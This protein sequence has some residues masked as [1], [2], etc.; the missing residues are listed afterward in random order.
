[1]VPLSTG[2]LLAPPC[3]RDIPGIKAR[4]NGIDCRYERSGD[5]EEKMERVIMRCLLANIIGTAACGALVFFCPRQSGFT[6]TTPRATYYIGGGILPSALLM[7][8][9]DSAIGI[10]LAWSI[11]HPR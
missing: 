7:C 6:I 3:L 1:M 5:S 11:L 2:Y 8:V 9:L 10:Y 4:A